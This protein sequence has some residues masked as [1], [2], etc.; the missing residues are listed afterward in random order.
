MSWLFA[1]S[2]RPF[3]LLAAGASLLLNAM[4]LVPALYAVQVFDRV[5]ASRSVE[6]LWML[7]LLVALALALAHAMDLL[8]A[9]ALAAVG[10]SLS[11]TL[12]APAFSSALTRAA[13]PMQRADD[14][15]LRDIARLRHCLSASGVL[16]LFEAP[17]LP[18]YLIVI[19]LL[20]PLLGVAAALGAALLV[21]LALLA[22]PLT[23]PAAQAAQQQGR[24]VQR[25]SRSLL[26]QAEVL[27]GMGMVD[28]ATQRWRAANDGAL[29][30]AGQHA[31]RVARLAAAGR[32]L[33]QALQAGLLGLGAWLVI[34]DNASPGIM[35]AATLLLSRALLPAEQLIG[36]W[37]SLVEARS[38]WQRL[39]AEPAPTPAG[40]TPLP[41]PQGR[42][43]L[44]RVVWGGSA[45]R[46]PLV[47]GVS[48]ALEHGQ[49]LGMVGPSG[50]GKTTLVRL[51]LGLR[52][53]QSGTVR[54]DGAELGQHD[55]GTLGRDIG[56][57]PQA[58]EL[59]D[60][61]VAEN[62]ARLGAPDGERV[63][64]AARQAGAHEMILRLPQ[65]YE[66]P[67]GEAGAAL[68]GGQRQR[69]GLARA[70]YG[71]PMLVVLDEPSAHLDAEGEDA[72]RQALAQLKQRG[73]SVVVISH[74]PAL[75]A[76]LDRVAVLKDGLI[77]VCGPSAEV[78]ARL[79][80]VRTLRVL[81]ASAQPATK[82]AAA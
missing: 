5:F 38:A 9:R 61:S 4:L 58:P 21:A 28:A 2:L 37:K 49:S 29:D 73:A 23:A 64:D 65:G 12:L 62:I 46:A 79:A 22:H 32:T 52:A 75:M 13:G 70:L 66:T 53:P 36:G 24:V 17:C 56:Y 60:G 77:E 47:K 82:E 40:G 76:A 63:I 6:T 11:R 34:H 71:T 51:M 69:I 15:P 33:R 50:A 25:Q 72:L 14:E 48:L 67:V 68:S 59:F 26:R 19:G 7:S 81:K 57:L 39:Q 31:D 27:V 74:R 43:E 3:V 16:A 10:D 41:A 78:L 55:R 35:V 42:L 44:E 45:G 8:R 18:V 1:S 54:L 30:A 80:P 20:H